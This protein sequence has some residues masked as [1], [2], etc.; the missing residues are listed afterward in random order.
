MNKLIKFSVD[1]NDSEVN[2]GVSEQLVDTKIE[3]GFFEILNVGWQNKHEMTLPFE[4]STDKVCQKLSRV[5]VGEV[6]MFEENGIIKFM[7]TGSAK[8][9]E[10]M[11]LH[12][13][14]EYENVKKRV[15]K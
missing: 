7:Q 3:K 2:I 13:V 12:D 11:V 14:G 4:V 6:D 8:G 10:T 5:F 9:A 1:K 15:W